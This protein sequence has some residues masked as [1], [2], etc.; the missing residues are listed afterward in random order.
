MTG[1]ISS[2]VRTK[3]AHHHRL[4]SHFLE[5]APGTQRKP[6]GNPPAAS[7]RI[8][9]GNDRV[10]KAWKAIKTASHP[11]DFHIPTAS[12]KREGFRTRAKCLA[13]TRA[14]ACCSRASSNLPS[15]LIAKT[16]VNSARPSRYIVR[17]S[18]SSCRER[19]LL[20]AD[21]SAPTEALR[22]SSACSATFMT[23][24][25]APVMRRRVALQA[26]PASLS[27][28]AAWP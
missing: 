9:H 10:W 21:A 24:R 6:M 12:T 22:N 15:S 18:N 5:G 20:F 28:Q 13:C 2:S 16:L 1:S 7:A 8:G 27:R 17:S 11:R 25:Y 23:P 14:S 26:S 19:L 4:I 3:V